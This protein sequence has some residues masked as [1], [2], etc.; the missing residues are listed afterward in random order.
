MLAGGVA[1]AVIGPECATQARTPGEISLLL[2]RLSLALDRHE[3]TAAPFAGV[4]LLCTACFGLVLLVLLC[5]AAPSN[6][7]PVGC[8]WN[9]CFV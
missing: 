8:G 3:L 1:G 7:N 6:P 4:L 5:S 2:T 9:L